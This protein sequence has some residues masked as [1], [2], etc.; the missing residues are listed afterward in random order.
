MSFLPNR[1][2]LAA[3]L[4]AAAPLWAQSE[5]LGDVARDARAEREQKAEHPQKVWTNEDFEAVRQ[6]PVPSAKEQKSA[7]E[8][9][10]EKKDS[11]TANADKVNGADKKA[12]EGKDSDLDKRGKEI[13]QAY[14]DKV[15]KLREDIATAQKNLEKLQRDQTA[16]ANAFRAGSA[17]NASEYATQQRTFQQQIDEQNKK[18]QDLKQSLEDAREAARHAGIPHTDEL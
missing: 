9:S 4:I 2:C 3:L 13:T 11:T 5:P 18:L 7:G 8:S 6:T 1:L 15:S 16:S 10:A 14:V 17:S 12:A